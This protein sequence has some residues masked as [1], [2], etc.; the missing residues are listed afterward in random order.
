MEQRQSIAVPNDGGRHERTECHEDYFLDL[1]DCRGRVLRYPPFRFCSFG[2]MLFTEQNEAQCMASPRTQNPVQHRQL[3]SRLSVEQ[4]AQ[5]IG[6]SA[7]RYRAVVVFGNDRFTEEEIQ[8]VLTATGVAEDRLR[9]W[10]Q[11]PQGGGLLF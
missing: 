1:R 4:A 8:Q 7:V 5:R 3:R 2:R 11:R 6:I 9:A 10:E